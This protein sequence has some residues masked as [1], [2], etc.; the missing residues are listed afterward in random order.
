M[1]VLKQRSWLPVFLMLS[2]LVFAVAAPL[3]VAVIAFPVVVTYAVGAAFPYETYIELVS[4]EGHMHAIP[5]PSP[6]ERSRLSRAH[7]QSKRFA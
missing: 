4:T 2:D 3:A 5:L 7:S 1:A 6:S